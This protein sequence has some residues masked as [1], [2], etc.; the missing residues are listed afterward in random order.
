MRYTLSTLIVLLVSTQLFAQF[1]TSSYP[2]GDINKISVDQLSFGLRLSPSI[3]WVD[4]KHNDAVADGATMKFGAGIVADYEINSILSIVSGANYNNIG[5]YIIDE[6]SLDDQLT[7]DNYRV[8]Y[9]TIEVP[10]G[11]R[12]QTMEVHRKIYYLQGGV[13]TSFILSANEK[14]K[15]TTSKPKVSEMDI[16]SLT[17]PSAV[18]YFATIGLEFKLLNSLGLFVELSYKNSLSSYAIG[19]NYVGPTNP[20]YEH[21][22]DKPI[23]IKPATMDFSVGIMF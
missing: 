3:A 17:T 22:Y 13:S 6:Q 23:D 18:G 15:S 2:S 16:I 8:N 7:E 11:L 12:I 19:N 1:P 9:S 20:I 5:G 10:L 4:V 21:G 14:R